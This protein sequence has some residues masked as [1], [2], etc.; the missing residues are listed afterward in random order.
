MPRLRGTRHTRLFGA[1]KACRDG[2]GRATY[3]AI[4]SR[5]YAV[6]VA[7]DNSKPPHRVRPS[8]INTDEIRRVAWPGE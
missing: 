2:L 6:S 1:G 7:Y 8:A 3:W 4:S 5:G